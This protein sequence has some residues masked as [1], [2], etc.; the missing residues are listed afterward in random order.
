MEDV[1]EFNLAFEALSL[2]D[3][4]GAKQR[5]SM[6]EDLPDSSFQGVKF[7]DWE[8]DC[9]FYY[10]SLSSFDKWLIQTLLDPPTDE[11]FEDKISFL[12]KTYPKGGSIPDVFEWLKK[13]TTNEPVKWNAFQPEEWWEYQ[14][15]ENA[16]IHLQAIILASPPLIHCVRV[17]KSAAHGIRFQGNYRDVPNPIYAKNSFEGKQ[18]PFCFV[19]RTPMED[20]K[21]CFEISL[22]QGNHLLLLPNGSHALLPL[23]TIFKMD[24]IESSME[25][26]IYKVHQMENGPISFFGFCK[27]ITLIEVLKYFRIKCKDPT[28]ETSSN[29]QNIIFETLSGSYR[30]VFVN[31]ED[32]RNRSLLHSFLRMVI[33]FYPNQKDQEMTEDSQKEE[34]EIFCLNRLDEYLLRILQR[35]LFNKWFAESRSLQEDHTGEK[36]KTTRFLSVQNDEEL[37]CN[38]KQK[39]KI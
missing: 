22:Q 30:S 33:F 23:G 18:T 24:C 6:E 39:K 29:L 2:C 21:L 34:S 31:C 7:S 13:D 35:Y 10:S 38:T 1:R 5:V 9:S 28:S 4:T 17:W 16:I 19:K 32:L 8:R 20:V 25:R 27:N 14:W 12:F 15:M 11:K 36:R 26:L 3:A 37:F